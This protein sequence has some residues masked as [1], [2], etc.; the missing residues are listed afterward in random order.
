MQKASFRN[1]RNVVTGKR[2][3]VVRIDQSDVW[4]SSTLFSFYW[5]PSQFF[6]RHDSGTKREKDV[7]T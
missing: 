7:G 2:E 3:L 6:K 5:V 4:R 1:G